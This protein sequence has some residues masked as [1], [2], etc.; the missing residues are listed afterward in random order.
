M[1]PDHPII[2]IAPSLGR[3]A[4]LEAAGRAPLLVITFARRHIGDPAVLNEKQR[5]MEAPNTRKPASSFTHR[6]RFTKAE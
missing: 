1:N 5:A 3:P 4:S 2:R 6:G